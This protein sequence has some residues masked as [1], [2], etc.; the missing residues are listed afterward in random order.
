LALFLVK[1]ADGSEAEIEAEKAS[2]VF[3]KV[4]GIVKSIIKIG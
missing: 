3:E 2:K 1:F 4:D